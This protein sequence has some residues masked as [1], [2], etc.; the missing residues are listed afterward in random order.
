MSG[1][2]QALSTERRSFSSVTPDVERVSLWYSSHALRV[3]CW[4][5]R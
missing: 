3:N 2:D 4:F 5:S 1:A